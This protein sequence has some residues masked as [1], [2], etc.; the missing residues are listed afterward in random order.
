[1]I[2]RGLVKG[3]NKNGIL[4]I[5]ED[6]QQEQWWNSTKDIE[7]SI[8]RDYKGKIVEI[9][10]FIEDKHIFDAITSLSVAEVRQDK[11]VIIVRQNCLAHATS[12]ADLLIKINTSLAPKAIE[13][14]IFNFAEKCEQWVWRK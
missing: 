6:N 4:L 9:R 3:V 8:N 7:A 5:R 14:I 2:I 12:Y 1:M 10:V 13:E 11:D